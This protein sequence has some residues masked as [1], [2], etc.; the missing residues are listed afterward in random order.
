MK[1]FEVFLAHQEI[2]F[3]IC[4]HFLIFIDKIEHSIT[5]N[6]QFGQRHDTRTFSQVIPCVDGS[7]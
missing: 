2:S 7:L 3:C 1:D 6:I 5:H 4:S